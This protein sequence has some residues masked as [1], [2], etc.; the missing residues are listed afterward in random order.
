MAS[1]FRVTTSQLRKI[2]DDLKTLNSKF[3][4]E[5]GSLSDGES[6]LATM[7]EGEAQQAFREEFQSDKGK[8]DLFYTGIETY[9]KRLE[10]TADAYEKAEQANYNTAKTRTAR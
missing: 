7:W 6:R 8:F 4:S 3:K 9:I 10:E 1:K 5:V 2:A